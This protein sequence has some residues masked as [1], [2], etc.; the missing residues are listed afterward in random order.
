VPAATVDAI[1]R[2]IQKG[3]DEE[4]K[5]VA[6]QD[7][8]LMRDTS[9]AAY[10]N[11]LE[12][13]FNDMLA[14]G[15]TALKLVNLSWGSITLQGTS[16]A[17]ATT[18]ETWRSTF[19]DGSTLE[20]SAT[21]VYT[22]VLQGGVWLVQDDQHTAAGGQQ[23]QPGASNAPTPAVPA[24]P[25][26]STDAAQSQSSNWS[27][28]NA[29]GGTY[30]AVAG[31]W[32]VPTVSSISSGADATWVGIGGM[33]SHDLIQAGTQA[34][35]QSG[36]V[37]YSAWWETLPQASQSIPLHISAG[38]TMSVS[39]TQQPNG[40][41]LIV[42]L[43]VTTGGVFRKSVAY[44]SSRSSAEWVEEAPSVG[45]ARRMGVVPLDD[46]G[47]ISFTNATTVK[48]G[49]SRTLRQAG[50]QP[51]TMYNRA[52]QALAQPSVVGAD[53][54]SFT[55]TRTSVP[56]L[57]ALSGPTTRVPRRRFGQ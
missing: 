3:N 33:S 35:V 40:Q 52:D 25:A 11:L 34:L 51:V 10:Y 22:L 4:V 2:V 29:T 26:A 24:L 17:Q 43:D 44:Q 12:Q 45:S 54:A 19:A 50:A 38:D 36:R 48:D 23:A 57:S 20:D 9:T 49:Q 13:G 30:T 14:S 37:V 7:A 15:V 16:S 18:V 46:F 28:Y 8:T 6:A 32:T 39:I 41:W 5:A 21:N 31:M 42:I 27:G 53:G 55:V 1:K 47:A 56:A